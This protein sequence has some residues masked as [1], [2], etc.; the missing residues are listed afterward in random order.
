M[1]SQKPVAHVPP[2]DA[3]PHAVPP[4]SAGAAPVSRRDFLAAT[5]ATG[6]ALGAGTS[7]S[8]LAQTSAGSTPATAGAAQGA[9]SGALPNGESFEMYDGTAAGAVLAQ[10]RAAGV[11]LIFNT[12]TSGFGPFW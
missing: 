9:V 3:E 7:V 2:T 8:A 6:I 10:L 11:R 1:N 5:A 12:N 4:Q